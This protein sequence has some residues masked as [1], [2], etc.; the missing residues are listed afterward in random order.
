MATAP[1]IA[2]GSAPAQTPAEAPAKAL[3]PAPVSAGSTGST[4]SSTAVPAVTPP[5]PQ[6]S[7]QMISSLRHEALKP[8]QVVW[9]NAFGNSLG[10][11][12]FQ[13]KVESESHDGR[14]WILFDDGDRWP[15]VR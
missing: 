15:M 11:Q 10:G 7:R 12:W 13:G 8:G 1:P 5:E 3:A 14:W 2:P 9:S 6:T 4:G